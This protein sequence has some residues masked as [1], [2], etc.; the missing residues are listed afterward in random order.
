MKLPV[1]ALLIA[2]FLAASPAPARAGVGVGE[3]L[4]PFALP[5]AVSGKELKLDAV[6]KGKA[7]VLMF[8]STQCPVSNDYNKRMAA[9]A[10]DY[11]GKDVVFVGI[12][13]NRQEAP[14]EIAAHSKE[15]GFTFP[16][17]KDAGN[18]KADDFGAKVTPEI[19]VFDTQ[20]KL[21][22]HGRIDDSR[23]EAEIKSRDLRA[24]L[25]AV[26]AGKDVPVPET[27]AFGCTIKRVT[28][29]NAP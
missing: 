29:A 1:V 26:L 21:R 15:H 7:L 20:W 8:I 27:K 13:S 11:T 6:H 24:A 17:L 23:N 28:A 22:Y 3:T 2:G 18:V 10:A 16:V 25:D 4:K 12:N 9:L 5:D 14:G 19:Y